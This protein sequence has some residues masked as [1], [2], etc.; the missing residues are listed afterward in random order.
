MTIFIT[1]HTPVSHQKIC[2]CF[3][4]PFLKKMPGEQISREAG[5]NNK[6]GREI[7]VLTKKIRF[8]DATDGFNKDF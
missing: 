4:S 2:S 8:V 3:S 6:A 7:R 5:P 1:N